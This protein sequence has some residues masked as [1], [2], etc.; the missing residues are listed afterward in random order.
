MSPLNIEDEVEEK[1][2]KEEVPLSV[3]VHEVGEVLL[4][5]M[6]GLQDSNSNLKKEMEVL[7]Y[8]IHVHVYV[9]I[10]QSLSLFTSFNYSPLQ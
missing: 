7:F 5:Q 9:S 4:Q 2:V 8:V 10:W 3:D 1:N 6:K